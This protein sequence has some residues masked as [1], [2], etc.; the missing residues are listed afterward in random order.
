MDPNI[1]GPKLWNIIYDIGYMCEHYHSRHKAPPKILGNSIRTVF[2]SFV[3]LLPCIYCRESYKFFYYNKFHGNP[4][5]IGRGALRWTYRLKDLV[6][7]KLGKKSI[8]YSEFKKRM[9]TWASASCDADVLRI[10]FMFGKNVYCQSKEVTILCKKQWYKKLWVSLARILKEIPNKKGVSQYL[11]SETKN[12]FE[13]IETQKTFNLFLGR[14]LI[15]VQ[16][17]K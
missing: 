5:P 9:D 13:K 16:L 4:P 7:K 6:N 1:W 15:R 10:L 11:T 8:P 12:L 2:E 17:K 3:S 14:K